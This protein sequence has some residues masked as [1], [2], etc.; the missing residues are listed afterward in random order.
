M[1]YDD[2]DDDDDDDQTYLCSVPSVVTYLLVDN[3]DGM[4]LS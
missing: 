4:T 2:D 3:S 1:S